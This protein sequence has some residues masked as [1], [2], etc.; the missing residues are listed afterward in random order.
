MATKKPRFTITLSPEAESLLLQVC[1]R[2]G[3]SKARLIE[4]LI[5]M[6]VDDHE[7]AERMKFWNDISRVSAMTD[8]E[9]RQLRQ[10]LNLMHNHYLTKMGLGDA[11]DS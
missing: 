7:V 9:K 11:L 6:V 4:S 1:K 8:Q 10:N 2:R 3:L 5:R